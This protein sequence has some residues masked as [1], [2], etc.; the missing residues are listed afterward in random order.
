MGPAFGGSF[1]KGR[2]L[3][4]IFVGRFPV[5]KLTWDHFPPPNPSIS[6]KK[7]FGPCGPVNAAARP[8]ELPVFKEN[9]F[10][11]VFCPLDNRQ[12]EGGG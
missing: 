7:I 10:I 4:S 8:R 12:I 1:R 3:F 9:F 11:L 6:R 2:L 5:L